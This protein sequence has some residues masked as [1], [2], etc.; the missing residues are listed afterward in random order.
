MIMLNLFNSYT[1]IIVSIGCLTLG[2][3][4]GLV[5]CFTILRKQSLLGDGI[6]HAALPGVILAFLL[7]NNKNIEVLL[8]GAL[9]SGLL[10]TLIIYII[11]KNSKITFDRA[12]AMILS[13][14]FGSGLVLLT[15]SQKLPNAKQAG[16]DSFIYGQASTLLERDLII[17]LGL[18]IIIFI[19]I[20]LLYKEF[21]LYCF[22]SEYC[23]SIGYN[24][25]L[26]NFIMMTIFV[27]TI[28]IG[29]QTV[30]VIL[31]SSMLVAP[32]VSARQW[33]NKLSIMLLFASIIGGLSGL[34][35]TIIS[36]TYALPTGPVIVIILSIITIFS[37]LFAP[38]RGI[39]SK[40]ILL[41]KKKT[42]Y[43][44]GIL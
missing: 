23:I 27:I 15:I 12:L 29:L 16:L 33:S 5:G 20:L 43:K 40:I 32:G 19:V 36:S 2:L 13:I 14:F 4:S 25:T 44:K 28:I 41:N 34:L 35:G 6:S 3:V 1:F 37:I 11:N 39:I 8:T 24:S 30:G 10:A 31:V 38:N 9:I 7:T 42:L 18:S 17:M 21:K 26:I 22:D